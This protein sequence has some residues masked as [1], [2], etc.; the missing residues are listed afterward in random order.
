MGARVPLR[1]GIV[2]VSSL[3]LGWDPSRFGDAAPTSLAIPE[4]R[5]AA[6]ERVL[7]GRHLAGE[8][9]DLSRIGLR[10]VELA[11]AVGASRRDGTG[12]PVFV[13]A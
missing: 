8:V 13:A 5:D 11:V 6:R 9:V 2:A 1:Q 3:G 10:V 12:R 4:A 7:D